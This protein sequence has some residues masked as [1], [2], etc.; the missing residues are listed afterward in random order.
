MHMQHESVARAASQ[1][2]VNTL[3]IQMIVCEFRMIHAVNMQ[4][5]ADVLN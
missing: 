4:F 1:N 5:Q 2:Y 3:N